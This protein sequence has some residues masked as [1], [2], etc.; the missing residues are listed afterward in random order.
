MKLSLTE[1]HRL[2]ARVRVGYHHRHLG[3]KDKML[4]LTG[5]LSL[6][7]VFMADLILLRQHHSPVI[8]VTKNRSFGRLDSCEYWEPLRRLLP[9]L[10][11]VEYRPTD[12]QRVWMDERDRA[13]LCLFSHSP[14]RI[15]Y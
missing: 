6:R 12:H 7:E 3:S 11:T 2:M 13:K 5:T 8:K 1:L 10:Q 14:Q 9:S 15:D 4:E